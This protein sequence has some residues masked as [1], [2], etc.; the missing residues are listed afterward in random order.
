MAGYGVAEIVMT[1]LR[2]YPDLSGDN[3]EWALLETDGRLISAGSHDIPAAAKCEVIV[4]AA[5]VLLTRATIPRTNKRRQAV[6]LSFAV[7]EKTISEPEMNHVAIA[8]NYPDGSVALAVIDKAWLMHMLAEL[9]KHNLNPSRVIPEIL[10]PTLP[11]FCWTIVWAGSHGFLRSGEFTGLA[12]DSNG[13]APPFGVLLALQE[14]TRPEKIILQVAAGNA[15]DIDQWQAALG[16][17]I[18][19][20][21]QWDWR[22]GSRPCPVNFLQGEFSL[23]QLD[24]SWLPKLRPVAILLLL[25]LV[26][27]FTGIVIDWV[28]LAH[29]KANLNA[30]MT[31]IFRQSFP[32]AQVVVDAPLQM[33]RKLAQL[34]HAA[35]QQEAGDFLPLLAAISQSL[36]ALP[37]GELKAIDYEPGKLGLSIALPATASANSLQ[38]SLAAAHLNVVLQKVEPNANGSGVT[39]YFAV[40]PESL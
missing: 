13:A 26:L 32:E 30:Q 3:F 8:G 14:S 39:A 9:K 10:L 5:K 12:L 27:Q 2:L 4:P 19:L 31:H 28:L 22:I 7:E 35:G 18:V 21:E 36:A 24:L 6:L 17:E 29:E 16:V 33:D 1:M 40:S 15:P 20:T 37:Q 25:M 38:A 34:R 11:P 23:H